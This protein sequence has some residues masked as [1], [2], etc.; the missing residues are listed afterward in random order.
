MKYLKYFESEN[1][2]IYWK[3]PAYMPNI[4]IAINKI[5]NCEIN[6][7]DVPLYGIRH[8]YIVKDLTSKGCISWFWTYD[9]TILKYYK[10]MGEITISDNDLKQYKLE[11]DLKKYNL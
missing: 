10:Y 9:M 11:Q 5:P 8:I 6:I 3:I 4:I 7:L 1:S 2:Y